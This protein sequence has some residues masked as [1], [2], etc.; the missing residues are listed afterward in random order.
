MFLSKIR[1][2]IVKNDF[3]LSYAKQDNMLKILTIS[4]Q[5][6]TFFQFQ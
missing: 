1:V 4:L 6:E 2:F 5:N 3:S